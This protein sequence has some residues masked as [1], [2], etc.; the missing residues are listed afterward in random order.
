MLEELELPIV[1]LFTTYVVVPITL[2]QSNYQQVFFTSIE[3]T[4]CAEIVEAIN[5]AHKMNNHDFRVRY[6]SL[7]S[8]LIE[9]FEKGF[10]RGRNTTLPL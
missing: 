7:R 9:I 1:S 5:D 4:K 3:N 10:N 8:Y 6:L 2:N